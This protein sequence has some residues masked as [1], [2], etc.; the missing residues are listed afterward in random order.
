MTDQPTIAIIAANFN[1]DI[2][3]PMIATATEEAVA[4][5]A[6]VAKVLRIP[7]CYEMPLV[8]RALMEREHIDAFAALGYIERGETLHGEVMGHIVHDALVRLQLEFGKPIGIGI[9]GPGATLDQAEVRKIGAAKAA[10]AAAL[11]VHGMIQSF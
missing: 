7:G 8:L 2:V 6:I 9:I 3:E 4:R 1:K 11:D 10:V 5:G